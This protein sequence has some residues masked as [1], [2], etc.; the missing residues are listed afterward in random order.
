MENFWT[1]FEVLVPSVGVGLV[2]WFAMR[3]IFRAD[4]NERAAEAQV[5][6]DASQRAERSSHEATDG[7]ANSAP[8]PR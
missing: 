6:E 1:Y 3:A 8:S 4:R 5:R 2:F 7:S